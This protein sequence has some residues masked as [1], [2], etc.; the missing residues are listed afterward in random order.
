MSN[1]EGRVVLG[2]AGLAHVEAELALPALML[3][4]HSLSA[5]E[6]VHVYVPSGPTLAF[7]SRDSR[8]SSFADAAA[9]GDAAGFTSVVRAPG[10]S[11]V[12]YD[13]G[14]VVV[15]HIDL[16]GQTSAGPSKFAANA[17]K[18][19]QILATLGVENLQV[20]QVEGEYCP[21]AYSVNVGGVVKV[22]GS[23]QR[24]AGRGALFSTVIQVEMSERVRVVMCAA[25]EALGYQL[26]P[27]TIGGL[28]DF[29]PDLT[30]PT[31]AR[32][33]AENFL[34]RES[35]VRGVIPD[36]LTARSSTARTSPSSAV[37]DVNDWSRNG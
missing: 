4:E 31:V 21:G 3:H 34:G 17:H 25:S 20:G 5:T 29:A 23:A 26:D 33:V 35:M 19:A 13:E 16:S 2:D 37:F 1:C 32:A 14:A 8:S 22:V 10:G 15:D 18:F 7:S 9:A 28:N 30:A 36:R 11:I 12:A 27:V 6:Y 24:I